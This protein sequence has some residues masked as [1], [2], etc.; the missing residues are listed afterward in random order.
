MA[1]SK[2][3]PKWHYSIPLL[4]H[5][6]HTY[7]LLQ[8]KKQIAVFTHAYVDF[9]VVV[10]RWRDFRLFLQQSSLNLHFVIFATS[11]TRI[12]SNGVPFRIPVARKCHALGVSP[13]FANA[14][15]KTIFFFAQLRIW[16]MSRFFQLRR[17]SSRWYS[18][19]TIISHYF[20]VLCSHSQQK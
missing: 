19:V 7:K 17:N 12:W 9:F 8:C 11:S 15:A 3:S 10:A 16:N 5:L 4:L 13:K 6:F 1:S 20:E 14:K 18:L 2:M